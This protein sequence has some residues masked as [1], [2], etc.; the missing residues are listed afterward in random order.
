MQFQ[1]QNAIEILERTPT[2][3]N[4]LLRNLSPEWINPNEGPDTWSPYDIVGH[5]IHGELTDWI[6]RARIILSGDANQSFVPFDRFAQFE[7]SKGKSIQQLLDEFTLLR[8][9]NVELLRSFNLSESDL[10]KT[11]IHPDFGPV[12]M[13]QLL[14][15]WTVHDLNHIGQIVRVMA[16]Q[17]YEEVGPWVPY[18][19]ILQ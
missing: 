11:G 2:V 8:Q 14:S 17:Y 15:T 6:P 9:Q 18:L 5:F 19:K 4:A 1:L 7:N 3:L 12:T 10:D 13:R 16:K